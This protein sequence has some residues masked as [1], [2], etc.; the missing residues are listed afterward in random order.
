MPSPPTWWTFDAAAGLNQRANPLTASDG[1]VTLECE[2]IGFTQDGAVVQRFAAATQ[3]TGL[4]DI[5]NINDWVGKHVTNTGSEELWISGV[6]LAGTATLWR[7]SGGV[8]GQITFSDTAAPANLRYMHGDSLNG[9]FFL[10]YDSNVNRLH[11]WDGTTLRRVGF[12]PSG[13]VSVAQMG[14]GGVS[15]TRYFRQRWVELS[16]TTVVRMS[17]PGTGQLSTIVNRLGT[18][19]TQAALIGEGETHWRL[20][21]SSALNGDYYKVAD[22]AVATTTYDYTSASIDTTDLSPVLGEY[23]PP[24]SAK[25]VLSDGNRILLGAAWESSAATGQTEPKQNRVWFTPVLGDSDEGDDERIPNTLD[26]SNWIDV[27]DAGPITAMAGPLYGDIIVYKLDSIW[28]LVPTSD[29]TTPYRAILITGAIGAVD[30]R[31][32][33]E[34]ETGN[35]NPAI[36]FASATSVYSQSQGGI[37][38]ISDKVSRDLRLSNFSAS[39][40]VL[41]YDPLGKALFVQTNSG[42]VGTTGLYFQFQYDIVRQRWSG[43]SLGGGANGWIVGRSLLGTDTVLGESGTVIRSAVTAL[44]TNGVTRLLLAGQQPAERPWLIAWGD[45]CATDGTT[46]FTTRLRVRKF[47]APGQR[48]RAGA[49]TV[50]YRSPSGTTNTTGTLSV[51]YL[52]DDADT[53]TGSTTLT[54]T[55]QDDPI[56][57]K[58]HTFDAMMQDDCTVLDLRV[59]LSYTVL[60]QSTMP[61]SIDAIMVPLWVN[62]EQAT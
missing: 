19:V 60:F 61:P 27:G 34:A 46:A 50:I 62:E 28:K 18:T 44:S 6:A 10:T 42:S 15:Y 36:Y 30:Q 59:L 48:F 24:P 29:A 52:R 39:Q 58:K 35:G 14:V 21:V 47:A 31:V 54:A 12:A 23:V 53:V 16:G 17:E 1:E 11:V 33:L 4:A 2:N 45:Q 40:S 55:G 26:Q 5:Q 51:S 3:T 32:V 37:T 49:P 9:K 22:T 43:I 56:A 7:R 13:N 20:E 8:W 41:G 38:D 25:Y 57:Q